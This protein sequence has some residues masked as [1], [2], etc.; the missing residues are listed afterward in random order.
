MM[1]VIGADGQMLPQEN[2]MS[3]LLPTMTS[4]AAIPQSGDEWPGELI[5]LAFDGNKESLAGDTYFDPVMNKC[6]CVDIRYVLWILDK[7]AGMQHIV[8]EMMGE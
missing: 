2:C 5:G 4:R 3:I 1:P 8:A 7:Y 6:V